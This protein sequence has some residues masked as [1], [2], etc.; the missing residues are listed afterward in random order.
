MPRVETNG[1]ESYYE[2]YG[3]GQP[4]VVLHGATADHQVWAEQLQPLTDDYRVIVYDLRG[5]GKTGGSD[6]DRYTVD[7]YVDDLAGF[8]DALDLDQPVVLGH[9]LGGMIG[10]KF[11]DEH[12]ETLSAL[13]TVGAMTPESFSTGERVFRIAHTRVVIPLMDNDRVLDAAVWVQQ[14]LF[15]DNST[16]DMDRLEEIRESHGCERPELPTDERSK[17]LQA[18]GEYF[19]SRWSRQLSGV[20]VLMLYGEDEP[21]IEAH[22]DYLETRLERCRTAEI[23]GASHNAHIDNPAFIHT[24]IRAFLDERLDERKPTTT[25]PERGR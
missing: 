9:S 12:P 24:Q 6:L 23:P 22:A 7:M 13:I 5:H 20:P 1:I 4:I 19:K 17:I 25:T 2:D 14:K 15:G 16:P 21:F 18:A 8:V 10:Y 11:A 3:D